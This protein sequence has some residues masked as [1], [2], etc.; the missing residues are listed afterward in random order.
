MMLSLLLLYAQVPGEYIS[1]TRVV[2]PLPAY[3]YP[4]SDAL[5]LQ[6]GV[7]IRVNPST[8]AYAQVQL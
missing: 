3:A 7:C 5:L 8:V 1:P 4:T 2:C 6:P